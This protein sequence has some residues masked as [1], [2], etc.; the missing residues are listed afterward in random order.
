VIFEDPDFFT[1]PALTDEM[2]RRAEAKLGYVLPASYLALAVP[3]RR[4]R[5]STKTEYRVGSPDVTAFL[6]LLVST[7]RDEAANRA[8]IPEGY[9]WHHDLRRPGVM[10]LVDRA[11]HRATGH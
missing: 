5:T 6:D 2:I 10:Q 8:L 7:D 9:T 1:G 4:S 3:S 11:A